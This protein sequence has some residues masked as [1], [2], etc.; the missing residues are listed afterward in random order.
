MPHLN[1]C[2]VLIIRVLYFYVVC[3]GRMLWPCAFGRM[4]CKR[5]Q[6]YCLDVCL[7]LIYLCAA[8]DKII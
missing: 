8:F 3:F 1:S 4:L 5:L 7:R 2:I 6:N